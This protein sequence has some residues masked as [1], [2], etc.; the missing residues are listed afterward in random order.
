[1]FVGISFV[2]WLVLLSSLISIGGATAYIRDTISGKSKP[3]RVSWF[4]W[5]LAPLLGVSAAL[6]IHA[7]LWA[8]VRVFLSGFIPLL[9]FLV[10]FVNPQSYWKLNTFDFLC[11]AFAVLALVLWGFA[12]SPRLAIL[13]LA[14]GDG[15]AALPT[16]FKAWKYPETETGITYVASLVSVLLVIPSIP[17]WNIENSAFQIYLLAANAVFVFSMYRKRLNLFR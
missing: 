5:A 3:N 6:S 9:V 7:D 8:V 12:D 15:C 17:V 1:M 11:G 14:I 2:H 16:I 10:S 13:L 4:M